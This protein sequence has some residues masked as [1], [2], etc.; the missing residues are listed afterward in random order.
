MS[1]NESLF[2][3][4]GSELHMS[5]YEYQGTAT[6]GGQSASALDDGVS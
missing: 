6:E 4:S 1:I 3:E 2:L 5:A